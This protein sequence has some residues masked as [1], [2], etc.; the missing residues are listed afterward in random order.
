MKNILLA[1]WQIFEGDSKQF[2]N[3]V[4]PDCFQIVHYCRQGATDA[5]VQVQL[6]SFH[7]KVNAVV[8]HRMQ[9]CHLRIYSK[10]KLL[11]KILWIYFFLR[12]L[13]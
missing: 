5:R 10:T 4:R 9:F 1:Y 13:R 12:R 8:S 6:A 3:D 11:Q 7:R 2:F